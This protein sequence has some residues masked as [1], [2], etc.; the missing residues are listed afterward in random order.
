MKRG[1]LFLLVPVFVFWGVGGFLE[2]TFWVCC[3]YVRAPRDDRGRRAQ[4]SAH[5]LSLCHGQPELSFGN[6]A[7]LG[8][9][10]AR[11]CWRVVYACVR[12]RVTLLRMECSNETPQSYVL[13]NQTLSAPHDRGGGDWFCFHLKMKGETHMKKSKNVWARSA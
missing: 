2:S 9:L 5:V 4:Y 3:F 7:R 8:S 6:P 13:T 10:P 12:V 11:V 1:P